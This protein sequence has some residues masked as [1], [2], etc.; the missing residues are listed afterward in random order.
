MYNSTN[1]IVPLSDAD[2][3]NVSY[4]S[5]AAAQDGKKRTTQ[6]LRTGDFFENRDKASKSTGMEQAS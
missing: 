1:S 6:P 2:I 5:F 3:N 4:V